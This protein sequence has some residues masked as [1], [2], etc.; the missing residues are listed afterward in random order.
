MFNAALVSRSCMTPHSR[1]PLASKKRLWGENRL[2]LTTEVVQAASARA[3]SGEFG[4]RHVADRE[5]IEASRQIECEL[6]LESGAGSRYVGVQLRDMPPVLSRSLGLRQFCGRALAEPD[7]RQCLA[8]RKCGDVFRTEI[9]ADAGADRASRNIRHLELDVEK[10]VTARIPCKVSAVF[11]LP[12]G[13]R[14]A[15][16]HAE[17][18]GGEA[19]RVALAF[20]VGTQP[21]DLRPR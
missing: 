11:D 19:K 17:G 20:Q 16:E 3:G 8:G 7:M 10:P 21:S 4:G 12:F 15:A 6:V 5:V 13:K 14:P 1:R 9:D 18:V 2:N